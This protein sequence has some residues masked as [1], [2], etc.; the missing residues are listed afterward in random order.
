MGAQLL[1]DFRYAARTLSKTPGF[2]LISLA[3]LSIGIAINVAAFSVVNLFIRSPL[4]F[5]EPGR[6]ALIIESNRA[7]GIGGGV[8]YADFDDFRRATRAFE[9]LGAARE[10]R[11]AWTGAGE[12]ESVP[13]GRVTSG[14]VRALRLRPVL[15][16]AF[17]DGERRVVL[18]SER[19]WQ[20]R[21]ASDPGVAGREIVL[22]GETCA[23]AGVLPRLYRSFYAHYDIWAPLDDRAGMAS[24]A[25]RSLQVAGRLKPDATFEQARAELSAAS[26]SI[27]QQHPETNE[28]WEALVF[29]MART[30]SDAAP[31]FA[32]LL[33]VVALV[34]L[35]LCANIANL[36]L[37]RAAGRR[38]EIAVRL[39]LGANRAR[40]VRQLLAEGV[41]LAAAGGA[42]GFLLT[43]W[44]RRI[45]VAGVP[46]LSEIS[47][48]AAV[49]AF[50]VVLAFATGVLFGLAPAL[51]A[52]RPDV[53][54]ALKSA[55]RSEMVSAGRRLRNA[56]VI[57]EMAVAVTLLIGL[58][59]LS[60]AFLRLRSIDPG[61]RSANL[62][63]AGLSLPEARYAQAEGRAA[64]YRAA[65]ERLAALPGAESAAA[66]SALPLGADGPR[67]VVEVEGRP[68]SGASSARYTAVTP[69]YFRT[70]G[71]PVLRGRTLD[72]SDRAAS[73]R[74]TVINERMADV[75]WPNGSAL[76]AR[77][78]VNSAGW[79]TV[80]GIVADMRQDLVRA[81]APEMYVPHAQDPLSG[82]TLLVRT[83][84]DPLAAAPA[85]RGEIRALDPLLPLA[86]IQS[87][88]DVIA[89]YFPDS[90]VTGM[91]VFCGL[92][93]LL[94][95]LGLYG[96][97]S[98]SVAQRTHEFGVRM[99][100]GAGATNVRSL[101]LRDAAKLAGAGAAIGAAAG[102][103]LA[104][105][106]SGALFGV[107]AWDP[108][109]AVSVCVA[110]AAVVAAASWLPARR[111]TRIPP[112]A[113]LR[114][115]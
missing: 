16:R 84:S 47:F 76:G 100:L 35:I 88:E 34:L 24:R 49:V 41:L 55:S 95:A 29:P 50:T 20:R 61:F 83:K 62:L 71:V 86:S 28:G 110:L 102:L 42:A 54:E 97:V 65:V 10:T 63:T 38:K 93:L 114:Y 46:E 85:V 58:G 60:Q 87:I 19:L 101:V 53:N 39:A 18:I 48:D 90:I 111:A 2:A 67:V 74:V 31:M 40:I 115:E 104:R 103:A 43:V 13:G 66:V 89:G 26:L 25:E 107:R 45:L 106:L 12:P 4:P 81:P 70:L 9:V 22:D 3:V 75:L 37:A 27:A 68:A 98:Y 112:V 8:S 36:Q 1:S 44:V 15:G 72:A 92:A 32:I 7:K 64:F 78:R 21:F 91:G 17:D 59:L 5:P 109:I 77:I 99:A 52:S 105:L 11:F 82:M 108:A 94:A 23:I 51:S 56:L 57:S 79:M 113:A 69:E 30:M 6:L 96:V 33:A 80:A 73:P 14:F